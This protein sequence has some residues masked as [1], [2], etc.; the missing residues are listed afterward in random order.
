MPGLILHV[1]AVVQ[2]FHQAPV[3]TTPVQQKVL[4]SGQPAM[5]AG[6]LLTVTGCPFTVGPK[7]QPCVTVRWNL[8][9]TKVRVDGQPVLLQPA[10]GVGPGIG[11]SAEQIPQGPPTVSSIQTKVVA[12]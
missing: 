6:N 3:Q 12:S 9:S 5:V 1:G 4:V 10:P 8:Q 11:Q 2:C 7:P